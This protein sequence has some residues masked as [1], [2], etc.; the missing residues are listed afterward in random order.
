M[1]VMVELS[2]EGVCWKL[3]RNSFLPDF[4]RKTNGIEFCVFAFVI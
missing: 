1:A 4:K 3:K 2:F